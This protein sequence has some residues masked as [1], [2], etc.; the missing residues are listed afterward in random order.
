MSVLLFLR[1]AGL[2]VAAHGTQ[3]EVSPADKLTDDLR[4]FIRQNKGALIEELTGSLSSP[5]IHCTPA[6]RDAT[7]EPVLI[8]PA[9]RPD[10]SPLSPV[11]WERAAQRPAEPEPP[12]RE[13]APAVHT[14]TGVG[15]SFS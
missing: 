1:K 10:G 7:D 12:G 2:N 15:A 3:I 14:E 11:F 6:Q 9:C 5:E 8:E 4:R 13:K